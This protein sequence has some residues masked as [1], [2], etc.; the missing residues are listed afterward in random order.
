MPDV[1]YSVETMLH[2]VTDGYTTETYAKDSNTNHIVLDDGRKFQLD[3][4]GNFAKN[5]TFAFDA[6]KSC[7]VTHSLQR[8]RIAYWTMRCCAIS[9]IRILR[10]LP[11]R[12]IDARIQTMHWICGVC[13]THLCRRSINRVCVNCWIKVNPHFARRKYSVKIHTCLRKTQILMISIRNRHHTLSIQSCEGTG[14]RHLSK[15]RIRFVERHP[16]RSSVQNMVPRRLG[17]KGSVL[18]TFPI[19]N[20]TSFTIRSVGR[21]QM[22]GE[23]AR[24]ERQALQMSHTRDESE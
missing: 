7:F 9:I 10:S 8:I 24:I 12:L 19:S 3:R 14:S 11:N 20:F 15:Y 1:E 23:T 5:F 17:F 22:F 21:R 18:W 6:N 4:A 16:K 13:W 2:G